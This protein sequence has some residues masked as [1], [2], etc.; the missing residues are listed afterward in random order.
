MYRMLLCTV[1]F[2]TIGMSTTVLHSA[3]NPHVCFKKIEQTYTGGHGPD[4]VLLMTRL[5]RRR[6]SQALAQLPSEKLHDTPPSHGHAN[7]DEDAFTFLQ[8]FCSPKDADSKKNP[9]NS[10]Q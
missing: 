6:S 1:I 10:E 4:R 5:E 8:R 7:P 2:S 3:E 9:S